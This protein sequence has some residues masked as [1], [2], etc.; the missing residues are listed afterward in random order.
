MAKLPTIL[1]TTLLALSPILAQ[2]VT[3][4]P[5]A[6]AL[7]PA[8]VGPTVLIEPGRFT[9]GSPDTEPDRDRDETPHPV[10]LTKPFYIGRHEV[11]VGEFKKFVQATG[12]K[13]DAEKAGK[14]WASNGTN[15]QLTKDINWRAPGFDQ[16]D[17]HPVVC[18]SLND[19]KAYC[20][21]LTTKLGQTVT[22]PTEAQWEYAARSKDKSAFGPGTLDETAW[23]RSNS[24]NKTHPV[25]TK[26]PNTWGLFDTHG[27]A[28]EWT[29]DRYGPYPVTDPNHP[30][31]NPQGP[32]SPEMA[33]QEK[34][35]T[36]GGSWA[37]SDANCRSAA[38]SKFFPDSASNFSGFRIIV[39][40][41]GPEPVSA[42]LD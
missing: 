26:K 16:T 4:Q 6:T 32:K 9:M 5:G 11:T 29:L 25:E 22:L 12:Y 37:A 42:E 34:H 14:A 20:A 40:R 13:T 30:R 10:R 39:L 28:M 21:W 36:R 41:S 38:R 23:R 1:L 24:D 35:V 17:N 2:D 33:G 3:T 27:N 7:D 8:I 19:A 31:K 15:T 18:I